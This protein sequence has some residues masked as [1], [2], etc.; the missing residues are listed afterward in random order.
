MKN[1]LLRTH[2]LGYPR[3]GAKREL[4]RALEAY[5][6]GSGTL[7]ELEAT[8]REL[9]RINW[10][11]QLA[12]DIDWIPSNDFSYY[13]QMLDV[14]C[15]IGNIPER[16]DWDGTDVSLEL[17]FRIARG[18]Q[19]DSEQP[20]DCGCGQHKVASEMTKWFD[21]NYHYIVPE[22]HI[23][24][25]F[26]LSTDKIF[27]EFTEALELGIKTVPVLI[28]PVTYLTLGKVVGGGADFD[29][30]DL[31]DQLLP[32]Y[33]E[34]LV[35]L[36]ELGAEWVQIDEPILSTDLSDQ[37]KGLLRKSGD[38][39]H[40]AA[41]ALKRLLA[42]YYGGLGDNLELA[43]G[44]PYDALHIDAVRGS[45]DEAV[46][47]AKALPQERIL[48][49]GVI[50]GRNIWKN[51]YKKTAANIDRIRQH[52][53]SR[54]L[55]I[56][57][58]CSLQHVPVNLD[59]EDELDVDFRN[60][61]AFADQKLI[62][63]KDLAELADGK[64]DQYKYKAN[65]NA[66]MSRQGSQ[67]VHNSTVQQ[68]IQSLQPEDSHRRSL[69]SSRQPQQRAQLKLPEFPTTT[70]GSFPQTKSVRKARSLHKRGELSD[71]G[72]QLI[73]CSKTKVCIETQE[74]IGLDV[75]VH[76][77]FERND[78]V[79]YFGEQLDGFAFT[80]FGWVQSYGS[81]C[82]KPPVLFGDVSRPK[83]MTVEWA[84]YAQSLTERYVKGMLTG[85][86]TILQWSFVRDDQPRKI[87][88]QQ[89]ALAIRDEVEDLEAAGI[90]IIQIDEAAFREGLPL[91]DVEARTY[92]KWAAEAFRL[93]AAG[94]KDETQIHT[95]MCYSD[96]NE[97]LP[98]LAAMDADVI[99]I[100]S[101]RSHME[102]LEAFKTFEY[103]AEIGPG[104]YDIHSPR[105]PSAG[106]MET[107]AAKAL[108]Y[109]PPG[110]FWIN[111]DCGLKTRGWAEVRPSLE[112]MV[113]VA[114]S[115]RKS[116]CLVEA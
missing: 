40:S 36:H 93:C 114:K 30:F 74:E 116:F 2:N 90:A 91:R 73:L 47:V 55:V 76:G 33:A 61:L 13:D 56:S 28:G 45:I 75:L 85:P 53:N 51:D 99:T 35:K 60:W 58:S 107:L 14:T 4:K 86:I 115:L 59:V 57:P 22:F 34:I 111:P 5:W 71:E 32:V 42:N 18:D 21:T 68:R 62:E 113:A 52:T 41:P 106:E 46:D 64:L 38:A 110:N 94:V 80:R 11:K 83:S 88:A 1:T 72:Y 6:S 10:Q 109:I 24:T 66:R 92:L 96:F 70:I 79:E 89:I 77:E 103:P 108:E 100:E 15:L 20:S 69:F 98:S 82:V 95:H 97:I 78:M 104:I 44:L 29:R 48:S 27:N 105:I 43:V 112:N 9:R 25:E 101:A 50:D 17:A 16:F 84:Q 31:I 49:V 23:G 81:R 19:S 87:S 39:L 12:A 67:R 3:I 37:Q 26:K 7:E 102:L 63:L 8:G 54:Q 65:I